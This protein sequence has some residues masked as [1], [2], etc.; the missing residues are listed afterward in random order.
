[1][2]LAP[3]PGR[4]IPTTSVSLKDTTPDSPGTK[5][6]GTKGL[7]KEGGVEDKHGAAMQ[8]KDA[9]HPT[10]VAAQG[11]PPPL[12][13]P[14]SATRDRSKTQAPRPGVKR[15]K[16]VGGDLLARLTNPTLSSAAKATRNLK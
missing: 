7:E 5:E 16:R 6:H 4:G 12:V 11:L 15:A 9:K 3:V 14:E 2:H 8:G 1:M 10:P 13:P